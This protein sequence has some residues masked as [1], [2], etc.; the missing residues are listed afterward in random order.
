MKKAIVVTTGR[1]AADTRSYE[2]REAFCEGLKRRGWEARISTGYEPCDLLV[3]WG[4]RRQDLVARQKAAGGEVCIL[5]R[6]YM[7]DRFHWTSVSF[8]GKLNNRAE[9]RGPHGDSSR[10]DRL[11]S[12]HLLPWSERPDGYALLIG[13]VPGDMSIR[14]VN[15]DSWYAKTHDALVAAHWDVRFRPHPL[16][17]RYRN[18][19][20]GLK[21][22]GGELSDAMR[23]AGVIVT[24]NSNTG[25]EAAL[26]GRPVIAADQGSMAWDVAGHTVDEIVTPDRTAWAHRLSWCQFEK[27]EMESGFCQEAVNL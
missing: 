13:Q 16:A 22:I 2:W 27:A 24:Y 15:I 12:Q 8:G 21:Q 3:L 25:V 20:L 26:A 18:S 17:G 23:G 7:G 6:G 4:T 9:F 5:E 1:V 14:D 10:F 19:Y 11:F